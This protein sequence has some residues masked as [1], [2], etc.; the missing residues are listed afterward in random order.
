MTFFFDLCGS[1]CPLICWTYSRVALFPKEKIHNYKTSTFSSHLLSFKCYWNAALTKVSALNPFRWC[2]C[3][4]IQISFMFSING[5]SHFAE[6]D[7]FSCQVVQ[8][9]INKEK[10]NNN[11]EKR[12]RKQLFKL[13]SFHLFSTM[14]PLFRKG[15]KTFWL[16]QEMF[17]RG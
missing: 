1:G 12:S 8:G 11:S 9:C 7:F 2:I 17:F 5:C 14:L 15:H 6:W 3:D 10:Y 4:N 16:L 13:L